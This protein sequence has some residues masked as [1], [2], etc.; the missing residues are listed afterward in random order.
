[1]DQADD[2]SKMFALYEGA[3]T[4]LRVGCLLLILT[5]ATLALCGQQTDPSTSQTLRPEVLRVREARVN[6]QYPV[7]I[8][9]KTAPSLPL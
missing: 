5:S 4:I 9:D 6:Q 8:S 2:P 3:V 7:I 1:M